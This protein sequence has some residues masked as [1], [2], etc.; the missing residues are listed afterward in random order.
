[1]GVSLGGGAGRSPFTFERLQTILL[2]TV[3]AAAACLMPAQNDTWWHLR[4]GERLWHGGAALTDEFSYTMYGGYWPNHEWLSDVVFYL[5]FRTGGMPLVTAALAALVTAAWWCSWSLMTGMTGMTGG[6]SRR[7]IIVGLGVITSS[8]QWAVRPQ[9]FT[10]FFV[11]LTVVLIARRAYRPLP[12]AFL[13]WANLHA[14]VLIGCGLLV[15]AAVQIV[16]FEPRRERR[17]AL[18]WLASSILV[19]ALTPLGTALWTDMFEAA[20]R[21]RLMGVA[22]FQPPRVDNPALLP[23]WLMAAALLVLVV[24]A[25]PTSAKSPAR[26]FI[27]LA[28][29]ALIPVA[30]MA[31]RNAP[32]MLLVA[33]PAIDRLL[34][35]TGDASAATGAR[36]DRPRLNAGIAA[37]AA[38][39]AA[40]VVASAWKSAWPRLA[41]TP[42]PAGAAEAI[43][44]CPS[45]VYNRF[46]EGGYLIWFARKQKVFIDSRVDPY[47]TE[48][49][50]QHIEVER[51]GD[52]A[53]LFRRFAI[54]CAVVPERSP[55]AE[56]LRRDGWQSKYDRQGWLIL[57]ATRSTQHRF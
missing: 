36:R 31:S 5:L 32:I 42:M 44:A 29:L 21:N 7:A 12:I 9:I 19:T 49:L 10:L 43:E 20:R 35:R 57:E 52:Y 17:A 14:G 53:R 50:R 26:Q 22:E 33:A 15:V 4:E 47:P 18:P 54:R 40:I 25:R 27:V 41:W 16:A 56:A 2:F 38:I 24:R 48:L 11:A 6:A 34:G 45:N 23:F 46:D 30:L 28:A 13:L 8:I 37:A 3:I 39:A 1:M 55:V 51:S